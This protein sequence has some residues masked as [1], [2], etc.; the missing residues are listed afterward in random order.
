MKVWRLV[1]PW[2]SAGDNPL[3]HCPPI[4]PRGQLEAHYIAL[5]VA[6]LTLVLSPQRIVIGGGVMQQTGVIDMVRA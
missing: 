5:A 6:N 1:Q 2:R 3:K 4:I